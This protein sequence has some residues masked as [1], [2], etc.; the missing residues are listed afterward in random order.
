[1]LVSQLR[2]IHEGVGS[3][4]LN[5]LKARLKSSLIM[6][7]E[8]S[9]SRSASMAA[10]WYHL[11]R[12]MTMDELGGIIDDLTC[13]TI[14]HYLKQHV[15]QQFTHVTLGEKKLEVPVGIS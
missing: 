14:N 12:V 13:E 8:S 10:D 11:G 2:E 6:Q 3:D 5:R 15:P 1:M 9:A 4:E 7:Q